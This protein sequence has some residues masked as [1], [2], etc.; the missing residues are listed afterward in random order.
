MI[1]IVTL[2]LRGQEKFGEPTLAYIIFEST[3]TKSCMYT[4]TL[5]LYLSQLLL[6]LQQIVTSESHAK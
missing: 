1:F 6:N 4:R 3:I 5:H 2:D